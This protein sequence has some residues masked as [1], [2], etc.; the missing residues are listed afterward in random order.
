MK[1]LAFLGIGDMGADEL[2]KM[3]K[4]GIKGEEGAGRMLQGLALKGAMHDCGQARTT[5]H[6]VGLGQGSTVS[7]QP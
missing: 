1:G 6:A 3:G 7:P 5:W 4:C 2:R